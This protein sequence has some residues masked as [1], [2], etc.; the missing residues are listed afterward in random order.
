MP[1]GHAFGGRLLTDG[2]MH[3]RMR[4]VNEIGDASSPASIELRS[5]K[6]IREGASPVNVVGDWL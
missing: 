3:A 1:V 2:A 4:D 6:G 5:H